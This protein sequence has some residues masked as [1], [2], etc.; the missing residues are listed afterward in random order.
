MGNFSQDQ[1]TD[2]LEHGAEP[3]VAEM[4]HYFYGGCIALFI[5]VAG[6]I[7]SFTC[8]Y[9]PKLSIIPILLVIISGMLVCWTAGSYLRLDAANALHGAEQA[10]PSVKALVQRLIDHKATGQRA[11]RAPPSVFSTMPCCTTEAERRQQE[12]EEKAQVHENALAEA[13]PQEEE[14]AI[15]V[16]LEPPSEVEASPELA[17]QRAAASK[18]VDKLFMRHAVDGTGTINTD[19]ALRNLITGVLFEVSPNSPNVSGEV[20]RLVG[21]A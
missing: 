13:G 15:K 1:L 6:V 3:L 17:Q 7:G 20:D 4:R 18:A 5:S 21:E 12:E 9:E 11:G 14:A 2:L 10:D 8:L 19:E 16:E